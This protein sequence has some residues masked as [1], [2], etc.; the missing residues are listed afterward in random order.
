M[1]S[2]LSFQITNSELPKGWRWVKLGE[3]A[4]EFVNGGTPSTNIPEYWDGNIPW[5]TGADVTDFWVSGGRKFI[6]E[7]GLKNSVTHLVPRNTVLVVT[8][9]GVGKV[10]IAANDLCFSQDITG[11][12]CSEEIYPEYLAWY[13]FSERNNLTNIQRGA[14]IKGLTRNDIES[15]QIPLPPLEEQKSISLK[16][17]ESMQEV[18]RARTDCEKQ[19]EAAKALPA[20]YLREVFESEEAKK[21]EKKRLGEVCEIIMGQSPPSDSYNKERSGLPF[22]QGKFDFGDY[23]PKPQIWCSSPIKVAKTSD[24]LVSVRAPVGPVNIADQECCIGRGI[25][26]LRAKEAIDSWFLFFYFKSIEND[27]RGRGSTFD[28]IRKDDLEIIS[29]P[30]PSIPIQRRIVSELKERMAENK[31]LQS[32]IQNQQSALNALPQGILREAFRGEL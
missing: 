15:L 4:K 22:F 14:T 25:T 12:I 5:I 6:T 10:G 28:A 19:L 9:T 24:V 3:V 13:I 32:A 16:I 1:N 29:V 21:W 7:D 30:L 26:A 18:E 27:W 8:R 20:A 23:F 17:Q 11:V 31:N 2:N